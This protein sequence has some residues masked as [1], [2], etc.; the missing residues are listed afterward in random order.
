[1]DG[2]VL[3][4]LPMPRNGTVGGIGKTFADHHI[5]G[6]VAPRLVPRSGLGN[7]QGPAGSQIRDQL[8]LGRALA[9]DAKAVRSG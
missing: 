8:A 9:L 6:D 7:P 5:L 1:M 3:V 2:G 4:P